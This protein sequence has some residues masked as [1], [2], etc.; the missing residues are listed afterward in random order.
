MFFDPLYF[1][2]AL[3]PLLLSLWA[4]MKVKGAYNKW[5]EVRNLYNL[6][7]ADTA[8]RLMQAT[9]L[10]TLRIEGIPGELTD[11]YDPSDKT[12]RLSE[13]IYGVP[14]VAAMA[15]SA[16]EFGHAMQ[17]ASGYTMM[18]IRAQLVWPVNIGSNLGPW[19]FIG[20]MLLSQPW[21]AWVG[22]IAF[23]AAV[24]F[25]LVTLPVE[26]DA[27]SRALKMLQSYGMVST[28]DVDGA[29][30]VLNAAAWTYV[31]GALQSLAILL[32]Y[33]FRLTGARSDD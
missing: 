17:D 5:S 33:V 7:G 11:H 16:H 30:E 10:R 29:K 32:Y 9:N 2:F 13:G 23:S 20:G 24:A 15:V 21:L 12:I 28:Q 8:Q 25:H 6:S 4:Q 3:P 31:A 19:L 1:L 14:S 22:V 27:S 18:R 26:F